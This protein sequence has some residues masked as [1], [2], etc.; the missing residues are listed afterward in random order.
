[1]KLA[2]FI[3]YY[4]FY[5]SRGWWYFSILQAIVIFLVGLHIFYD[6]LVKLNVPMELLY[7]VMVVSVFTIP[8][9]IGVFEFSRIGHVESQRAWE[10]TPATIKLC[11]Q[12][13]EIHEKLYEE[14]DEDD[15]R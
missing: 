10:I 7:V 12:I 2:D 4:R 3:G 1:M 13:D 14:E 5:Y 15:H 9:L 8:P 11:R 6:S